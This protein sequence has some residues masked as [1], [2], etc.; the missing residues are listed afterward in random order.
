MLEMIY[1]VK[2]LLENRKYMHRLQFFAI[3]M[4]ELKSFKLGTGKESIT[5]KLP[6]LRNVSMGLEF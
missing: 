5:W 3:K 2:V 6:E 4:Y 1:V